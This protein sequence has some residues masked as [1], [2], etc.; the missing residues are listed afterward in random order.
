M[1]ADGISLPPKRDLGTS[2]WGG[3]KIILHQ[4]R[5]WA[6]GMAWQLLPVG[7]HYGRFLDELVHLIAA[8]ARAFGAF[9]AQHVELAFDVAE[10]EIGSLARAYSITSSAMAS[11]PGG[12]LRP[13]ALAVL[14]LITNS[15]L[16]RTS[17]G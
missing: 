16:E 11:S 17:R 5:D 15:N 10:D 2:R 14:R 12:K 9:D 8:F 4:P 3:S 13:N 1:P 7:C 6:E